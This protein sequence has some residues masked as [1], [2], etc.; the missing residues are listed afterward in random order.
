MEPAIPPEAPSNIPTASES[1]GP[2]MVA[3][4]RTRK[5]SSTSATAKVPNANNFGQVSCF[6]PIFVSES[7]DINV[8]SAVPHV[9][10]HASPLLPT[11]MQK[12]VPTK[13]IA[14]KK[15][16]ALGKGS[17]A[18]AIKKPLTV[19]LSDFPALSRFSHKASTSKTSSYD[20]HTSILDKS[21][22]SATVMK[23]NDDPNIVDGGFIPS[24][25]NTV[26][27]SCPPLGDPSNKS[28]RERVTPDISCQLDIGTRDVEAVNLHDSGRGQGVAMIE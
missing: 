26:S 28:T 2:W 19:N 10:S 1:F 17:K 15:S 9:P 24:V 11:V 5:P 12:S 8:N 14:K 21:K 13:S 6:Q 25:L 23:E 20:V 7:N 3:T 18:V 27:S 22:H 16:G 4:R